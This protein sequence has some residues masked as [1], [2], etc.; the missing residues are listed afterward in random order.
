MAA[1]TRV[2]FRSDGVDCAGYLFQPAEP[3]S[4]T[5]ACIVMGH[6]FGGTMD[7][8]FET[9]EDFAKAG[10]AALLFDYRSF[11]ASGGEPRQVV[12]VE[13]QRR[14]S[15]RRWASR[16]SYAGIDPERIGLWGNSLG[17]GH[18]VVVAAA[19]PRIAAAVSQIPFNGFPS[20]VE[21]RTRARDARLLRAM[22]RD[23]MRGWLGLPP[24]LIKLVGMPGEVAITRRV[25]ARAR[26]GA[27]HGFAMAERGG[28]AGVVTDDVIPA[29][30]LVAP[31]PGAAAGLHRGARRADDRGEDTAAR[32][33]R[34]P[35]RAAEL[36]RRPLRLLSGRRVRRQALAD[37]IDFFR[38]RYLT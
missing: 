8:L 17:G 34:A 30:R 19:D 35:R 10:F 29:R 32:G 12:D 28:A 7:R 11:G 27:G 14:T 6:G 31:P 22:L 1:K 5:L 4:G 38:R 2:G 21:G 37:Q 25:G 33:A 23:S 3:R 9:A 20:S 36:S 26:R 24:Y 16:A 15:A 13:G 18:V